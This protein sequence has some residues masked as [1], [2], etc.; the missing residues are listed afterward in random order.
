MEEVEVNG[1]G[2]NKAIEFILDEDNLKKYGFEYM[3]GIFNIPPSWHY[4]KFMDEKDLEVTFEV[5]YYWPKPYKG[6][7]L[8]IITIDDDWGQPY[9]YQSILEK[10][11]D[12][13]FALKVKDF[14]EKEMARLEEAGIIRGHKPGDYI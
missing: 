14:A 4:H 5:N 6:D 1:L 2:T 9:D 13:K 8:E 10:N 3:E 7:H 11:P 12:N